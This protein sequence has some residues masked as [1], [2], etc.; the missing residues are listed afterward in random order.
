MYDA[1]TDP[2][3]R[4]LELANEE[5]DWH[6]HDFLGTEHLLM[7][8]LKQEDTVAVYLLRCFRIDLN[9]LYLEL[10]RLAAESP[11][12]DVPVFKRQLTPRARKVIEYAA[13]EA[14]SL[15]REDVGTG[16][17]LLGLLREA[18]GAAGVLLAGRG[19]DADAVRRKVRELES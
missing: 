9:E 3:L 16:H 19:L 11:P 15:G 5:A 6:G 10:K 13:E 14:R 18:E 2:A 8:L 7:G 17:L 12:L 1:F 4:V